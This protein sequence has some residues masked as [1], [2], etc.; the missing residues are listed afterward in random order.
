MHELCTHCDHEKKH[1]GA[2][3]H[4]LC[5]IGYPH[6]SS[7]RCQDPNKLKAKYAQNW[8]R[9]KDEVLFRTGNRIKKA[10]NKRKRKEKTKK[11]R[12]EGGGEGGVK[13]KKREKEYVKKEKRK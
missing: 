6:N 3:N 8:E 11:R 12:G 9:S 1:K 4:E 10:K 2:E 7:N 5:M 13:K